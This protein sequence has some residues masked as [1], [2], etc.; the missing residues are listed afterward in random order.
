MVTRPLG[1]ADFPTRS[2]YE[3]NLAKRAHSELTAV[4]AVMADAEA[5]LAGLEEQY[6][7]VL[8][9]P[10]AAW[11]SRRDYFIQRARILAEMAKHN[12]QAA[13]LAFTLTLLETGTYR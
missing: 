3:A 4:L 1:V 13:E 9:D 7:A 12:H 6:A 5:R 8:N 10:D 2:P 11:E